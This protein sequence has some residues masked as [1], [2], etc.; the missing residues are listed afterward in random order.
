MMFVFVCVTVINAY[1]GSRDKLCNR[2]TYHTV[3]DANGKV[4]IS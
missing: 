3:N 2:I 4:F 1:F